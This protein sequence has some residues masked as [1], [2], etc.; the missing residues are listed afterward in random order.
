MNTQ[1]L[2]KIVIGLLFILFNFTINFEQTFIINII[3]S[4]VGYVFLKRGLQSLLAINENESFLK[5]TKLANILFIITLGTFLMDLLGIS[6]L[7]N[8]EFL[9]FG[10]L[11]S[12]I[13]MLLQLLLL[14]HLTKGIQVFN[15]Y[16][17]EHNHPLYVTF[18]MIAIANVLSYLFIFIDLIALMLIIISFI[19]NIAYIIIVNK[20]SNIPNHT[21]I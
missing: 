18:L 13:V 19:A 10:L 21:S 1:G 7:V 2:K 3:P 20:I 17:T 5:T 14:Y 11:F 15:N 6:V 12:M 8:Q 4:F 16:A 9:L